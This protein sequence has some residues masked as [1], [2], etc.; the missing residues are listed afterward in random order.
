MEDEVLAALEPQ[1]VPSPGPY[2]LDDEA[3]GGVSG[4]RT[5]ID[6]EGNDIA[7]TVGLHIDSEDEANAFMF[8]ASWEMLGTLRKA[9]NQ[10]RQTGTLTNSTLLH[11]SN[12]IKTAEGK[13]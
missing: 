5:I 4:C 2:A 7:H 6:V 9:L 11:M 3:L 12:V 13:Q 8:A 10:F 1:T